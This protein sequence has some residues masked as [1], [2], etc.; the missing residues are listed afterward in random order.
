MY[1]PA[2]HNPVPWAR[3]TGFLCIETHDRNPIY[4]TTWYIKIL[5]RNFFF[6]MRDLDF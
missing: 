5:L 3:G 2:C 4:K 1:L 6:E